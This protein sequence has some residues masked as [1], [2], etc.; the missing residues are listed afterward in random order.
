MKLPSDPTKFTSQFKYVEV[1]KYVP[2]LNRI[3]RVQKD[4]EPVF[5][6]VNQIQV[7]AEENNNTGIYTSVW[8]YNKKSLT[9]VSKLGNLYFDLD[10]EDSVEAYNESKRLVLFLREC[11]IPDSG[12]RVYFTGSK[13]FHVECEAVCLGIKAG[14]N[15]ATL[16]R[17]IANDI[18]DKLGL[19]TLDFAVYDERRMWRVPYTI[20]QS[21]GLY[22]CELRDLELQ[23]IGDIRSYARQ[24]ER[25][26]VPEQEFNY[27]ANEWYREYTYRLEED[28]KPKYS[29]S[30]LLERFMKHGTKI[31]K[32]RDDSDREFDP[33]RLFEGC[34]S[35][36]K[37][38]E[39]AEKNHDLPHE[40]RLF[41][42]SILTYT[43]ESIYYLHEI[44][45]NCSDYNWERSQSH[46]NDWIRRREMGIGGRPYT[47][48]RANSAGVGC[49]DCDLAPKK[50]WV[51]VNGK[52]IETDDEASPSPIRYGYHRK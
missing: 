1:A 8:Q 41:L 42:C 33:V 10:S 23:S 5:W 48:E 20:H 26:P 37:W 21:T 18:R 7:F 43:E 50:K 29:D 11:G 3:I 25:L 45:K 12:V 19:T 47:C 16:F 24:P 9:E 49:G 35:I 4:K 14:E 32:K 17:Y 52:Y 46:I 15:L 27:Q 22:K 39:Y 6:D 28:K 30:E 31:L 40:A 2:D 44:L 38:W 34:P 51:E 13:G 36:L